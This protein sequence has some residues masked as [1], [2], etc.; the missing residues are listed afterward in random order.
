LKIRLD[1]AGGIAGTDVL[2]GTGDSGL[3]SRIQQ[4]IVA[5]PAIPEAPP[6]TMPLGVVVVVKSK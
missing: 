6:S 4:A 3:D 5:M 2:A 1:P